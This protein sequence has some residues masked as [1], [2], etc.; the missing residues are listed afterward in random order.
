M[1]TD[2]VERSF[3][4]SDATGTRAQVLTYLCWRTN[5]DGVAWPTR[6]TIAEATG[7]SEKQ[8]KR[9]VKALVSAGELWYSPG[10]GRG[11]TSTYVPTVGLE[12]GDIQQRLMNA[13]LEKG[14]A[15]GEADRVLALRKGD[16]DVQKGDTDGEKAPTDGEDKEKGTSEKRGHSGEEKGTPVGGFSDP[17]NDNISNPPKAQT[18]EKQTDPEDADSAPAREDGDP[19][20]FLPKSDRVY[21]PTMQKSV[22]EFTASSVDRLIR[23]H[24]GGYRQGQIPLSSMSDLLDD[25]QGEYGEGEGFRRFV[26]AVVI[27]G[28]QADTPNLKFVRSTVQNFDRY[29]EQRSRNGDADANREDNQRDRN[30]KATA[31]GSPNGRGGQWGDYG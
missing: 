22:A 27:A 6:T 4:H 13:G 10:R 3:E 12:K 25:L 7:V 18:M 21:E 26:A 19:W 28:D 17:P 5:N 9:H 14:D 20:S 8:V 31:G 11:N 16:T 29:R 30:C 24:W 2:L 1:S 23:R 15:D